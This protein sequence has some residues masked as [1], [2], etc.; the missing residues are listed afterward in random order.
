MCVQV[1]ST[2]ALLPSLSACVRACMC[3]R[4]CLWYAFVNERKCLGVFQVREFP[5]SL[6]RCDSYNWVPFDFCRLAPRPTPPPPS[7]LPLPLLFSGVE[8]TPGSLLLWPVGVVIFSHLMS[9]L[10]SWL[11]IYVLI[12]S[13]LFFC[14]PSFLSFVSLVAKTK[15]SDWTFAFLKVLKIEKHIVSFFILIVLHFIQVI[16]KKICTL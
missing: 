1:Y 8:G 2:C 14:L 12:F 9:A 5:C 10:W 4:V 16:I 15:P 11:D 7:P 6:T 3:V 13:L